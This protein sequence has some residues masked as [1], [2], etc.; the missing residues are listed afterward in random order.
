MRHKGW[1]SRGYLPHFDSAETVQFVTFRLADSLPRAVAEA[2]AMRPDNLA[3]TDQRL[4]SGLGACWLREAAV[5]QLVEDAILHFDGDRYRLLA[6]C[7]MPN[8]VHVVVEAASGHSLG[9]I[10][11]S[12]K[13]FTANL[14]NRALGRSGP[15]WH[16]DYFDRFIRDEGHLSRT[17][18]YIENNP[19]K[20]GLISTATGWQWSSARR[21][22]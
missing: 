2:L 12:W 18:E 11:R 19:V 1:H 9:A 6:W 4:D 17:I 14:A 10:V 21:R 22:A 13:S 5:A 15:F 16:R 3:E 20:A 8:H 7:V